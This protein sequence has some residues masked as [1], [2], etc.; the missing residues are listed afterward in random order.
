VVEAYRLLHEGHHEEKHCA[1]PS[2]EAAN[3]EQMQELEDNG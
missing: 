3:C 1:H 2:D